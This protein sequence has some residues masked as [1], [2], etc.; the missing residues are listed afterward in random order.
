MIRV[1]IADD[2]AIVREGVKRIISDAD[3]MCVAGEAADGPELL[4]LVAGD[5]VD[6]VLLD[7][8]MPGMGGLEVIQQIHQ[9]KPRLAVLVVSMHA[10][11]QYAVRAIKAGAAGYINKG[12][13]PK[14]LLAAIR[15]VAAGRHYISPDVAESLA[16]HLL[17]D[18]SKLPHESLSNREYEVLCLIASG[19]SVGDIAEELS[20]SIKTV[21][22]YRGRILGKLGLRHN[23]ELMRYALAHGLVE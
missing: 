22:T 4:A 10:A 13:P 11:D 5:G 20:L 15:T 6:V 19:K 8:A 16:A 21:S 12:R 17:T 1:F 2:H 23:A 9:R 7:L 14:E 3:D 18:T